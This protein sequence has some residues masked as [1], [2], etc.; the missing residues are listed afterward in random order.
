MNL[1]SNVLIKPNVLKESG[2]NFI[3][4][5]AKKAK[6]EDVGVFN[7]EASNKNNK[8]EFSVDKN[9]RNAQGIDIIDILPQIVELY[10]KIV[11]HIINPFYNI[12]IFDSEVPQLLS[13]S[14]DGFYSTHCDSE[15]L[16]KDGDGKVVWKKSSNRDISSII[17]LN[18]NFTGG[19]L[20]FPELKIR[21]RPEPGMLVCFPSNHS[22]MHAVEPVLSG[23]RI[24]M[25]NWMTIKQNM[26]NPEIINNKN[27][28]KEEK[29]WLN[30]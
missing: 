9:S 14:K 24:S 23:E 17:F 28:L 11:F 25:V 13:Y 20:I 4:D 26:A 1:L 29:Q 7:A 27:S 2:I 21:I 3:L 10:K 6:K 12:E 5:H 19:D 16:W 22:Y 15:S 18:D 30:T 8:T